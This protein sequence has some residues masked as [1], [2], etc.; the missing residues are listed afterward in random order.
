MAL[1]RFDATELTTFLRAVDHELS[2]PITIVLIGGSALSLGYGT[3]TSTSD[4]DTYGSMVAELEAAAALARVTTGLPVGI[5]DSTIAQLPTGYE[6]RL[7]RA[8]P[9]LVRLTVLI[10]D[11]HDLAA[12]KLLRGNDHDRQQL[13][14]LHD[15][16]P[17]DRA[18]LNERFDDLLRDVVGDT[19]EARWARYHLI[20]ELWTSLDADDVDPTASRPHR[21]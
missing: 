14:R 2:I 3:A 13:K 15:L 20:C 21:R 19:I 9:E 8:L 4:I 17:L 1:R 18:L 11:A 16:A 5:A 12:S 6:E 7:V 10:V